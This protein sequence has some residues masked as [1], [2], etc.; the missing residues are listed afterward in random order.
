MRLSRA[1]LIPVCLV[2]PASVP[3]RGQNLTSDERVDL[4]RGLTA[5]YATA[6]VAVPRSKKALVVDPK[7]G[8]DKK[9]W[10]VAGREFGP[11]ARVGDIVQI[12][13]VE[14]EDDRIVFQLNGGMKGG[15]KWYD[16]IQVGAGGRTAPIS[17]GSYSVAP[18][19]TTVALVFPD[20]LPALNTVKVKEIMAPVLDFNMRSATEHYVESLPPEIQTA[21]KEKKAREGMTRDQVLLA[22]GR[23]KN[24]VRETKDGNELEDWVYGDPP[25]RIT[26]VTFDGDKVIR[27]KEAYAGLGGEVSPPLK[28]PL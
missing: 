15:R 9:H 20:R 26:F 19:G 3:A 18:S 13:K 21:I 1:W 12:T 24:K 14:L 4:I 22:L 17:S 8:Y 25:G 28:P 11:A 23:P 10:D 6:K 5:E 16:R 2:V 27:V 7:G